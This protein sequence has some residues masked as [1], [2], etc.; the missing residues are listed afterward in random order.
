MVSV[1]DSVHDQFIEM[2]NRFQTWMKDS[3]SRRS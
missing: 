3:R 2:W 1:G